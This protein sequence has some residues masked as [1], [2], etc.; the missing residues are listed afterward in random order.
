[1]VDFDECATYTY[2][3]LWTCFNTMM[4]VYTFFF[5]P[6]EF[7]FAQADSQDLHTTCNEGDIPLEKR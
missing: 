2:G 1:M 6:K 4:A 5:D 7:V 3:I